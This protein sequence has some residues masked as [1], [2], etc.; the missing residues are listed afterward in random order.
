MYISGLANDMTLQ[1]II[2]ILWG[3]MYIS[4]LAND[5]T[6]Q[7]LM[8]KNTSVRTAKNATEDIWKSFKWTT[9][10]TNISIR[11]FYK[12]INP[13]WG[14]ILSWDQALLKHLTIQQVPSNP[15]LFVRISLCPHFVSRIDFFST[16]PDIVIYFCLFFLGT[17]PFGALS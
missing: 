14:V 3:I 17:E 15:I 7:N 16:K 4:G 2:L 11:C 9:V 13:L 10:F 8:L 6:V 12:P 1:Y 5:M